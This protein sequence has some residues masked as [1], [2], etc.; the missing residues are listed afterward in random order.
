MNIVKD[1]KQMAELPAITMSKSTLGRQ[2]LQAQSQ[3][4]I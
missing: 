3:N 4:N 2:H 1:E